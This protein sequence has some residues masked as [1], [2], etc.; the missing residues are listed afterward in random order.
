MDIQHQNAVRSSTGYQLFNSFKKVG[1]HIVG[2][3]VGGCLV[4][5]SVI[6]IIQII[7]RY[8]FQYPLFWAE[9]VNRLLFVWLTYLGTGLALKRGMHMAI[10][11][12]PNMLMGLPRHVLNILLLGLIALFSAFTAFY[13]ALMAEKAWAMRTP[14]LQLPRGLF[15]LALLFGGLWMIVEVISQLLEEMRSNNSAPQG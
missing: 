8:F 14:A 12:V 4:S 13:G 9:E 15:Y 10:D 11:I 2:G 7:L 3:I 1:D 5:M 6:M